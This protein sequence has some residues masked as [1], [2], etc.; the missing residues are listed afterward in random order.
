LPAHPDA[1]VRNQIRT[2]SRSFV[3]GASAF[4]RCDHSLSVLLAQQREVAE[5]APTIIDYLRAHYL[6]SADVG[7]IRIYLRI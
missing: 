5:F 2:A 1:G 7:D 6:W 3:R 4:V